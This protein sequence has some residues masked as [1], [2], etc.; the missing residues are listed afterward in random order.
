VA[1]AEGR[2]P[3][4]VAE[5]IEGHGVDPLGSAKSVIDLAENR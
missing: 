5:G 2:D 1:F 3:E 4:H